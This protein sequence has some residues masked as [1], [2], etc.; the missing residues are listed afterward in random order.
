[1]IKIHYPD[2]LH[3][4]G[5]EYN[6]NVGDED[7]DATAFVEACKTLLSPWYGWFHQYGFDN[8]G[9]QF[10]EMLGGKIDEN[11]QEILLAEAIKIADQLG[12][13]IQM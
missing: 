2:G 6:F 7:K 10:F 11:K 3:T 13:D 4:Y 12:C 9:Y 5:I 8:R 1:M